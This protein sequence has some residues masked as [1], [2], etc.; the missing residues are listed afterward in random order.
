MS[1][2]YTNGS[3]LYTQ[4]HCLL[5]VARLASIF[6]LVSENVIPRGEKKVIKFSKVNLSGV[7][8]A[9]CMAYMKIKRDYCP[10]SYGHL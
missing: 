7:I 8:S 9:L 10:C 6:F 3:H 4:K 1:I 5:V 2:S